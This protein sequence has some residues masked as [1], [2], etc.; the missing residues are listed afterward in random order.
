MLFAMAINTSKLAGS[1][2]RCEPLVNRLND[3]QHRHRC[4]VRYCINKGSTWFKQYIAGMDKNRG[5]ERTA[6]LY[7][8]VV[9]QAKLGNTGGH[10]EWV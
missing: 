2:G 7:R 4:E 10:G 8:D 6:T 9:E 1:I 5:K 3:E